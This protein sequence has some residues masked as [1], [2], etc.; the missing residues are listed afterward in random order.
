VARTWSGRAAAG[1]GAITR[2]RHCDLQV[3]ARARDYIL[4]DYYCHVRARVTVI[5]AGFVAIIIIV[6]A[7]AR[8]TS[9]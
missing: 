5:I 2:H 4:R 9:R 7:A 3:L 8:Y 1:R 6:I